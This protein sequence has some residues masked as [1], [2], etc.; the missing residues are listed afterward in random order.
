MNREFLLLIEEE[1]PN[2]KDINQYPDRKSLFGF[3]GG[4]ENNSQPPRLR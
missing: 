4:G 2:Q 3:G 1:Y